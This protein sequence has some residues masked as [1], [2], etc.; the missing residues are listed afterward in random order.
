MVMTGVVLLWRG[1]GINVTMDHFV[2][3]LER[4]RLSDG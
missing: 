1:I 4:L 3:A 2:T